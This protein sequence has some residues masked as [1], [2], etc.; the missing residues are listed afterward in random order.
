MSTDKK[1]LTFRQEHAG[2]TFN[3][4]QSKNLRTRQYGISKCR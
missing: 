3:G 1:L 4:K 2:F